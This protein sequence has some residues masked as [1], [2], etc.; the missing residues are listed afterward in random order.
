MKQLLNPSY[1]FHSNSIKF[2]SVKHQNKM[3]KIYA[4][5]IA[6]IFMMTATV[7]A[8]NNEKQ[9]RESASQENKKVTTPANKTKTEVKRNNVIYR[10]NKVK[11]EPAKKSARKVK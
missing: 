7:F 9:K 8:Q 6:F 3:K 4:A 2:V 11:Q 5:F 1:S 10:N